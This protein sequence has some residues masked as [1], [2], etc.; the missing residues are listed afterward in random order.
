[1]EIFALVAIVCGLLGYMIA[2]D[3]NK[4]MGAFLGIFLGP[5]GVLISVFL[6]G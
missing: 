5:L 6:K 2:S 3:D 1:M 4:V